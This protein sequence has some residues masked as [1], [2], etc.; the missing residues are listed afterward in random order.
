MT[1]SA[2]SRA[3]APEQFGPALPII[4]YKRIKDAIAK[5][6]DNEVGLGGSV[7]SADVS[8]AR[9]IADQLECGTDWLNKHGA[10][11]PNAP[12][13]GIKQSGFGVE[14]GEEGLKEFTNLQTM[15]T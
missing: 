5:A 2:T 12:F 10:N 8:K 7:G 14:F 13:G 1:K 9:A 4:L 3:G 15:I 6:N 11:Q